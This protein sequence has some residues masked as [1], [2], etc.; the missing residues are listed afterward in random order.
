LLS[1]NDVMFNYWG[2]SDITQS[3]TSDLVPYFEMMVRS[4]VYP[5]YD[6]DYDINDDDIYIDQ[7]D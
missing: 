7:I 6:Y 4:V 2:Y 5:D 3:L 1:Y